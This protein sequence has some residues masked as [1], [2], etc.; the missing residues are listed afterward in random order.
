MYEL[1]QRAFS[2]FRKT[3]CENTHLVPDSRA[4]MYSVT[5]DGVSL[6][7][8]KVNKENNQLE[9]KDISNCN[10]LNHCHD[11]IKAYE[12]RQKEQKQAKIQLYI[13]SFVCLF[14]MIGEIVGGYFAGSLAVMTDA[15][16]LLVDFTSFLISLC[17]LWLSSKP[18]TKKLNFGWYRAALK[19]QRA[20]EA[21]AV[22]IFLFDVIFQD[23][24]YPVYSKFILC[25]I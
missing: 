18:A 7:Q 25:L 2:K 20:S 13:A 14:F 15:A 9:E 17:S 4:R 11:N 24:T 6:Q 5:L 16:H 1:L 19:V 3:D 22:F 10:G 12:D 23:S 8:T 21:G